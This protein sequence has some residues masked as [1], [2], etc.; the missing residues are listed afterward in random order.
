MHRYID[1]QTC[2]T[3]TQHT[4]VKE[5]IRD[6]QW[7]DTRVYNQG[8]ALNSVPCSGRLS[9]HGRDSTLSTSDNHCQHAKAKWG[10]GPVTPGSKGLSV[11][12]SD[13]DFFCLSFLLTQVPGQCPVL[14][15]QM[16][17]TAHRQKENR[18]QYAPGGPHPKQG[19]QQMVSQKR[20]QT[21]PCWSA[22]GHRESRLGRRCSSCSEAARQ[23]LSSWRITICKYLPCQALS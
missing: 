5:D 15:T 7:K 12:D 3:L 23:T 11:Q 18:T 13:P 2:Q 9:A 19:V 21:A 14:R 8:C 1:I 22:P 6:H 17:H 20:N 4:E 16:Q 10:G